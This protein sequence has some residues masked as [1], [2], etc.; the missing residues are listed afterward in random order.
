[1]ADALAPTRKCDIVMKGGVT[2]GIVYP[3]A[4]ARLA[5]EYRFH[6]IG[7]TSAGAIA[8]ALTAAAEYRRA[9]GEFVFDELAGLPGCL[10]SPCGSAQ[11]TNLFN[12]FQPQK[13]MR[14]L[15]RIATALLIKSWPRRMMQIGLASWPDLLLGAIPGLLV[16]S[17]AWN[18][19]AVAGSLLGVFVAVAGALV[20]AVAG[21]ILRCSKLRRARFGL[22]T[23]YEPPRTDKP[24]ALI[25]WLN[26]RINSLAG[27]PPER[28]LTFGDLRR[29]GINL[30]MITT[31]VTFGR[32]Y[33]LPFHSG[34]FYF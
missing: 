28:P 19:H 12:L 1:M 4:V 3:L 9:H 2:S 5:R 26:N 8:A 13:E 30:Q 16:I 14:G 6:S 7:G 18:A 20:A 24:E 15:F 10:G 17:L 32:P 21:A 22:C 11:G 25:E 34:E 33:T 29:A 31:A 23:G 27:H